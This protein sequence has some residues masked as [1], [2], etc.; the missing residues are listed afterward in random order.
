[1]PDTELS[2][3]E[4]LIIRLENQLGRL[5]ASDSFIVVEEEKIRVADAILYNRDE[6]L[7]SL[8]DIRFFYRED[9]SEIKLPKSRNPYMAINP[10]SM[11]IMT[12]TRFKTDDLYASR[13]VNLRTVF[14][15][16]RSRIRIK[17]MIDLILQSVQKL[18]RM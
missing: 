16:E 11:G 13:T 17:S 15:N 18:D 9:A 12:K 4:K 8:N 2:K 7:E 3:E 5:G 10:I 1:M 6:L 14:C